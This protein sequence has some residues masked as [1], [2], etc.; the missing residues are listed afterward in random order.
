RASTPS[1]AVAVTTADPAKIEARRQPFGVGPSPRASPYGSL[2][3]PAFS[4]AS[5]HSEA[6][7]LGCRVQSLRSL[8]SCPRPTCVPVRRGPVRVAPGYREEEGHRKQ[9]G[10]RKW[11]LASDS[12]G[13][14][15]P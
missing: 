8:V 13:R 7:T 10:V 12:Q 2:P 5:S 4:A 15:L 11:K 9:R 1:I 14:A 6:P 3:P